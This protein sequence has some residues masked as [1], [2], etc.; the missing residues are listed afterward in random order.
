VIS[1]VSITSSFLIDHIANI[2]HKFNRRS[3]SRQQQQLGV[4]LGSVKVM[5]FGGWF[6]VGRS[7]HREGFSDLDRLCNRS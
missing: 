5:D 6:S 7:R 4:R 1:Q 3:I 2:T